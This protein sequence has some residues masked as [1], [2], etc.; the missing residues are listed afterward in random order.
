MTTRAGDEVVPF[1][2]MPDL[3]GGR[4]LR[5]FSS[6][7]F[8]DRHSLLVTAEYRWYAQEFLEAAIFYDAG[9][10]ASTRS[11]LDF[12]HLK[13]DVGIGFRLHTPGTTLLRVEIAR[14][15]ERLRLI[16]AFSPV[17]G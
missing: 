8:R 12:S 10:V 17:G 13:S 7:R 3:G 5:G 2:L 16:I 15:A 11:D 14:S 1:F 9:K 4:S 6:Y